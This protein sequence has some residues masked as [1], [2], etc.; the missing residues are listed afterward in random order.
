[1][2]FRVGIALVHFGVELSDLV[3]QA[4]ATTPVVDTLQGAADL[5]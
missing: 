1:M 4:L 2:L 5:G 3:Q